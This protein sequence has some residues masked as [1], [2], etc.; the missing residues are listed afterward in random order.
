LIR[1][2]EV[3]EFTRVNTLTP[4]QEKW[5]AHLDDTDSVKIYPA[6]PKATEKFVKV[7]RQ[8]QD[9]L[10]EQVEVL[11]RG[12]TSL[13]I[14][15]QG[16]LDVYIPVQ[17][18]DFERIADQV[19]KIFGKPGS[20]YPMERVRFVTSVDNT[21]A[22]VFVINKDS[23]GWIDSCRFEKYLSENPKVL[24]AYRILK[25]KSEGLSTRK[26]YRNK[27]EFINNVLNHKNE[28]ELLS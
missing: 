18:E 11:H 27:I 8:I 4:E 7:K 15:G 14:S 13:G 16:E 26:Y 2:S 9:V 12:A 24:E 5:L 25:E 17:I 10:G 20:Y 3:L 22:E 21:K 23:K 1:N 28:K 6:D 19:L